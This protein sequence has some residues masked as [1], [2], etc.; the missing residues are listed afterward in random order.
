MLFSLKARIFTLFL[1]SKE[2]AKYLTLVYKDFEK[3]FSFAVI[4]RYSSFLALS[5]ICGI[6]YGGQYQGQGHDGGH[7]D[8]Y[9]SEC[10]NWI[11]YF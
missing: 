11:Q 10:K 4:Q 1:E 5:V 6:A 9:V 2:L 8:H 7:N 3:N